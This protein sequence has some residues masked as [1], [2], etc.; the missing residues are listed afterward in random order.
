PEP[1]AQPA[2]QSDR[3]AEVPVS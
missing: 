3:T 1:A 2:A